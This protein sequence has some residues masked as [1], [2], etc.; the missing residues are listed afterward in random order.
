MVRY[1][2]NRILVSIPTLIA[3]SLVIFALLAMAPGDPLG[4]FALNPSI[5]AEVREN[6][7]RS[8]GLDQ[9][10]Y[11]QYFKWLIA[12][13]RGDWGWSFTSLSPVRDLVAQRIGVT[14]SIVGIAY[15]WG[16]L[17]AIPLGV[18]SAVKR[19]SVLDQFITT[20]S[21]IGF[22]MPT[23]FTGL[24]FI[25]IF[26]VKLGWLPFVYDTTI[27]ISDWGSFIAMLRQSIMP[28]IVLG[29]WEM[30]T[31]M[32]FV[33]SATL[34]SINQDYV[35]T[36]RSKGLGEFV[37]ISRHVL[38]NSL[39][40]VVT[41]IALRIPTIF[42]GALVTEQV[43]RIPGIGSLLIGGIQQNDTPVV[44]TITLIYA[45][46]V[47]VFNLIADILYGFL[48]PRVSYN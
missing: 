2:V 32:R 35:R 21:F 14:L 12:F 39:I 17:A 47:V 3:T 31:L 5:T 44:M 43:F 24:L 27:K 33:R 18:L 30:A 29:L 15:I 13:L 8:L 10:V 25:I 26:S 34:E 1:L 7:R 23:Y 4:E 46:L 22:S 48:D 9:P 19:Y 28:I 42:A 38:R 37:V 45:A 16:L 6:I 20:F 41:L 40:P 11:I 36:A